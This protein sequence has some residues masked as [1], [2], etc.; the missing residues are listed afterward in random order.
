[1]STDMVNAMIDGCVVGSALAEKFGLNSRY[2][3][4]NQDAESLNKGIKIMKFKHV[5]LVEV[6]YE[7]RPYIKDYVA[8]PL[9]AVD[10]ESK[11]AYVLRLTNKMKIGFWK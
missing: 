3:S 2:F 7:A 5:L 1:M 10:D 9:S 8:T 4:H 11:F 6:P